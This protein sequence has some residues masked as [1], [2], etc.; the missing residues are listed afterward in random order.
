MKEEKKPWG[1]FIVSLAEEMPKRDEEW[2][3]QMLERAGIEGCRLKVSPKL[4]LI[5]RKAKPTRG[6]RKKT[7]REIIIEA[8]RGKLWI[9]LAHF[10]LTEK[11]AQ[12]ICKTL[13]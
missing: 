7:M 8:L 2:F 12:G 9:T 10:Q 5:A 4:Q 1:K 13:S 3:A 6:Y 11:Q